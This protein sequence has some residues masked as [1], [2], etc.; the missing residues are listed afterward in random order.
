MLR[1]MRAVRA[2]RNLRH[3]AKVK[4]VIKEMESLNLETDVKD[5]NFDSLVNHVIE[6]NGHIQKIV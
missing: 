4:N 1:L 3:R 6:I 2:I 5:D